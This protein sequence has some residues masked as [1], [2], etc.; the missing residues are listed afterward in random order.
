MSLEDYRRQSKDGTR[1]GI[2]DCQ[3]IVTINFNHR[4][5]LLAYLKK[6]K[7]KYALSLYV[8]Y[9]YRGFFTEVFLVARENCVAIN[10]T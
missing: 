3:C 9:M 4:I 2:I 8:Q 7:L 6:Y 1:N 10:D 5:Q